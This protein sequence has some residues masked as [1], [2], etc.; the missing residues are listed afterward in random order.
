MIESIP[1]Q[2]RCSVGVKKI[3]L[4]GIVNGNGTRTRNG[5]NGFIYYAFNYTH[6]TVTF[7][8]SPSRSWSRAICMRNKK[9]FGIKRKDLTKIV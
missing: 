5:N 1:E 6:Y 9:L 8:Q 2:F 4:H 7:P 3:T